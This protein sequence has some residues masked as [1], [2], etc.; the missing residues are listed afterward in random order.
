M[1]KTVLIFLSVALLFSLCA[2]KKA[3]TSK[4]VA[5]E[6]FSSVPVYRYSDVSYAGFADAMNVKIEKTT[7]KDFVKYIKDLKK[8]GFEFLKVGS[9]PEN[10]SLNNGI[11]QWRCGNG[12]AFLQLIFSEDGTAQHDMFGCNL[13]IFG[14]SN[15]KILTGE[16]E[17]KRTSAKGTTSASKP[18]TASNND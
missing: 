2:C 9:A 13:Q 16:E 6:A 4:W 15:S 17:T 8:A 18:S 10:Y 12:K 7:Y 5:N 11:A 3:D 14:Y 1:K